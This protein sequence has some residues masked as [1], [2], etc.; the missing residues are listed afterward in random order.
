MPVP[1]KK[2]E[3][4]YEIQRPRASVDMLQRQSSFRGF[5]KLAETSPFKRQLSLQLEQS[6]TTNNP[7]HFVVENGAMN[8][9]HQASHVP[10]E[11][12]KK[13]LL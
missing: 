10:C 4:L 8:A 13:S 6:S 7:R 12:L 1:V 11:P 2:P 3:N 9:S 5:S